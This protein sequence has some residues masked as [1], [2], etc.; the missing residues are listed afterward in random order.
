MYEAAINVSVPLL[1]VSCLY[2]G[3]W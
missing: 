1:T 2:I 3:W